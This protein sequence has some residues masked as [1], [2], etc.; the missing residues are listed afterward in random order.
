MIKRKVVLSD[1]PLPQDFASLAE[2]MGCETQRQSQSAA[3]MTF[4]ASPAPS[5][6]SSSACGRGGERAV[7]DSPLRAFGQREVSGEV[8][9]SFFYWA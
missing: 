4:M 8:A 9:A 5:P 7:R 3:S 6:Q 1:L 2:V